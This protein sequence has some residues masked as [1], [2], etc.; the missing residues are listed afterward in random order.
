MIAARHKTTEE[1]HMS[2]IETILMEMEQ[3]AAATRRLLER[4]PE[5][6][7]TWRP[8]PK[9]WSLGQLALHIAG[10]PGGVSAIAA[11]D[12]Y[13]A[14]AFE[15]KEAASRAELLETLEQGLAAARQTLSA[16][17][18]Q[19]LAAI[20][21]LRAGDRTLMSVPRAAIIRTIL[22]NHYY[23]HRGQLAVY[24]RLLDVPVPSIYGPTADENPFAG[25]SAAAVAAV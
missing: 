11:L 10:I 15:Q 17:D 19:R 21:T 4:V 16:M 22:L 2:S 8:H 18:D 7:L 14:P 1:V 3:E 13:E 6:K 9:S 20:W 25:R 5:D 12:V 23:H 24:L